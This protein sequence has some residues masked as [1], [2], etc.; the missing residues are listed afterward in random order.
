MRKL[1]KNPEQTKKPL[2]NKPVPPYPR[3]LQ[4]IPFKLGD[5]EQSVGILLNVLL[6]RGTENLSLKT[7]LNMNKERPRSTLGL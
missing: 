5:S 7:N 1:K 2:K 6:F 4:I 3:T